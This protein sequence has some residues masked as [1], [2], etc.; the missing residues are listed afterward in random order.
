MTFTSLAI[1]FGLQLLVNAGFIIEHH[2][3]NRRLADVEAE[4]AKAVAS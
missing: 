4:V 1:M 3:T 2:F